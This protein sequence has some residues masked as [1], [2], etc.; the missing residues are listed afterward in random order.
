MVEVVVLQAACHCTAMPDVHMSFPRDGTVTDSVH[1]S[2]RRGGNG[3]P[4]D[5]KAIAAN[6]N[7]LWVPLI[8][9]SCNC[10][11]FDT[12]VCF[13][14]FCSVVPFWLWFRTYKSHVFN[15]HWQLLYTSKLA[16]WHTVNHCAYYDPQQSAAECNEISTKA[17]LNITTHLLNSLFLLSVWKVVKVQF[18]MAPSNPS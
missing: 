2:S 18:C 13:L 6:L 17:L 12:V 8:A 14:F 3:P 10:Y 16:Q 11:Y 1:K 9:A 5:G 15:N 7:C 4:R